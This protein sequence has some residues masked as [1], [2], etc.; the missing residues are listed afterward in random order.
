MWRDLEIVPLGLVHG[1]RVKDEVNRASKFGSAKVLTEFLSLE[2]THSRAIEWDKRDTLRCET[3]ADLLVHGC[4]SIDL[5]VLVSDMK[6]PRGIPET[7][8]SSQRLDLRH[9]R[10]VLRPSLPTA[11]PYQPTFSSNMLQR[12]S[13]LNERWNTVQD[14]CLRGN[15]RLKEV[16]WRGHHWGRAWLVHRPHHTRV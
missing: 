5:L 11:K 13:H 1:L 6:N 3:I 16:L 4:A 10:G 2:Q 12:A 8:H 15:H 7:Y 14:L 9:I